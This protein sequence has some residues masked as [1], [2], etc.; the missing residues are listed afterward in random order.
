M[1]ASAAGG[2]RHSFVVLRHRD[3]ALFWGAA[4]VSNSG[5]WMQ[6]IAAPYV[7]FQIT[8]STTWLGIGAFMAFF[9]ALCMGPLAGSLADRFPRKRILIYTQLGMMGTAFGLFAAWELGIATRGVIIGLLCLSGIASG[10]NITAWQSFVPQL[11]PRADLLHAV[12]VNSMQFVAAR[13]FGPALA[14]LVLEAFGAG[15]AFLINALSF[16][17][18][19][20]ALFAIHPRPVT[21]DSTAGRV[22]DHF[23]EAVAYVRARQAILLP[24]ITITMVSFLGSSIVQLTPAF[25]QDAFG[26]GRSAY[27]FLVSAFGIGAVVG[28]IVVALWA[29]RSPRSRVAIFGIFLFAS[30]ELIFGA[31]PTYAVGVVGMFVMGSAYVL[32]ATALNTSIQARVDETHRGRAMSIYLMGLLAGV[33]LGSL[34]QGTLASLVGLRAT[35]L[36]FGALLVGWTF[37]AIVRY[38]HFHPLD[39]ALEDETGRGPDLVI[40]SPPSIASAD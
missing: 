28:S 14:G 26:V 21:L 13:A 25:A 6:S 17:F 3:Y 37:F 31:A 18:V 23:R 12:R 1:S 22:R 29:E 19:L 11:V 39:E 35:V 38:E 36:G 7:I 4:L 16:V 8:K 10:L 2:P 15:T 34:L 30:G 33:P 32:I 27:G 40:G 24:V 9:P 20:A 5:S